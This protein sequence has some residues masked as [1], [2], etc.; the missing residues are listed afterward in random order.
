MTGTM[1]PESGSPTGGRRFLLT[2]VISRY[3]LQPS[4]NREELAEDLQR[5]VGLF[6][7]ELGYQHVPVMGLDPTWLQIQDAL[8][9]FCTSADRRADDYVVVYLAGH[10]EILPVGDTG[11]EH[12][13]LPADASPG[14]LRRRAV[15]SADLAEWMLADTPVR[16]LLLIVDE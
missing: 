11:F 3:Q 15:K 8:R 6:T 5:M 10:G 12:V 13:L 14:D 7:G 1:L 4:W 16:R 2:G 9:D